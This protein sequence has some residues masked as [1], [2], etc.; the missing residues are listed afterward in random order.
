MQEKIFFS[1]QHSHKPKTMFTIHCCRKLVNVT[2]DKLNEECKNNKKYFMK[3]TFD[4]RRH[5][6]DFFMYSLFWTFMFRFFF[7][8]FFFIIVQFVFEILLLFILLP[9]CSIEISST[10]YFLIFQHISNRFSGQ[11]FVSTFA[12]FLRLTQFLMH[13]VSFTSIQYIRKL[14]INLNVWMFAI[15]ANWTVKTVNT[16]H[17]SCR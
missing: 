17:F 13:S 4:S 6:K 10:V 12:L 16:W 3:V 7:Y 15:C 8:P 11:L 5:T 9:S 1:L 2:K 14:M